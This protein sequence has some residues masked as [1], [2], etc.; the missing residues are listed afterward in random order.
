MDRMIASA[1]YSL[2]T[3]ACFLNLLASRQPSIHPI[4][5]Q[6]FS[7]RNSAM[8][9]ACI[10]YSWHIVLAIYTL[11]HYFIR[12]VI[13]RIPVSYPGDPIA[14]PLTR[15]GEH[16]N[17]VTLPVAY[18][19]YRQMAKEDLHDACRMAVCLRLQIS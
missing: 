18:I 13:L 19:V 17:I 4:H 14:K 9:V 12:S 3:V 5:Q 16:F 15:K 11:V 2:A 8:I 1:N 6:T 10:Q 7:I